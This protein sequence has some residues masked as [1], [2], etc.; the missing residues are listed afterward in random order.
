MT[1]NWN[2]HV[3]HAEEIARSAGFQGLRDRILE[4]AAPRREETAVD[5]GSGTGLLALP[6]AERV[7]RVWAIDVAPLMTDYLRT[8]AASAELRNLATVTGTAES[9]PLVDASVD[10]VVS[11]Y[12]FHHLHA[13]GKERALAEAFR[14]LKSGGRLVFGDM[15]FSVGLRDPRDRRVIQA[16][17]L[18]IGRRG[19]PG[20]VRLGRNA[21]RLAGRRWEQPASG[22]WWTAALRRAGFEDARVELLEHEGGVATATRPA[23]LRSARAVDA[24]IA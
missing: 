11:N 2:D 16:K 17:V 5:V 18:A 1:K 20:M 12:C 9:L 4:L 6:L 24:Q 3:V 22:T 14:V 15:M 10:L 23:L 13:A 19:L 7:E 8:K 21:V